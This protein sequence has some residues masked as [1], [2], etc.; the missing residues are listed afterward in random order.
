MYDAE[1]WYWTRAEEQHTDVIYDRLIGAA[2]QRIAAGR[3]VM[4]AL[5][6]LD[7]YDRQMVTWRVSV[8]S[9]D[10]IE[11]MTKDDIVARS[12]RLLVSTLQDVKDRFKTMTAAEHTTPRLHETTQ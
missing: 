11:G 4:D 9:L 10:E 7:D 12:G 3:D 2:E 8:R 1:N 6:T 5:F